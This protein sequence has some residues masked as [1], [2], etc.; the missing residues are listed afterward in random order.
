MKEEN[1]SNFSVVT[2]RVDVIHFESSSSSSRKAKKRKNS[3]SAGLKKNYFCFF[4]IEY[5]IHQEQT[6]NLLNFY[7][8]KLQIN[9]FF[10]NSIYLQWDSGILK[11]CNVAI[12]FWW[13]CNKWNAINYFEISNICHT[14]YI[15]KIISIRN[16]EIIYHSK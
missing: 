12:S 5:V 11:Y 2:T 16:H 15:S 3:I 9:R 6:L 10:L 1:K 7:C 4:F 13:K 8:N 14:K